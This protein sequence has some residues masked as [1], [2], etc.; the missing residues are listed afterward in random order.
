[1]DISAAEFRK[2][3]FQLLAEVE[4]TNKEII[5]TKRGKAVA[6]LTPIAENKKKDPL[7][8][9]LAGQ[10]QTIGDLTKPVT[11]DSAWELD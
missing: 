4:E 6:K 8:G 3:I 7:L 10:G 11:E 5:I 2:K 9:A 1:M